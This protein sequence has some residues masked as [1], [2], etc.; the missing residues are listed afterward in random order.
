MLDLKDRTRDIR[1]KTSLSVMKY[2]SPSAYGWVN[3]VVEGAHDVPRPFTKMLKQETFNR[4]AITGCEVG[5]G[6]GINAENLLKELNLY[7]L[8]CVDPFIG[9]E[10]P[11]AENIIRTYSD[12]RKSR[13][14]VLSE[15]CS[16]V[17]FVRLPSGKAAKTVLKN[18]QFDFVY[19]DGNHSYD[20]VTEDLC[21]YYDLVKPGGWIGGHDY[22]FGQ[23]DVIK[24]VQEFAVRIGEP[25][26]ISFPDFWFYKVVPK[27]LIVEK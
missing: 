10:Y 17:C 19:I 15:T 9:V 4:G 21:L 24:A 6:F 16:R 3:G 14:K 26:V 22:I 23:N 12:K 25:P 11:Q 20:F 1:L 13:F 18:E 5:F 7:K 8:F 27:G 2:L